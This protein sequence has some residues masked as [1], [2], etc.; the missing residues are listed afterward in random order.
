MKIA[1]NINFDSLYFPLSIDRTLHRDP[2]FFQIADRFFAIANE[3]GISCTLFMI[4]RDLENPEV[5][6]RVKSWSSEGHEIG[7]HSWTHHENLGAMSDDFQRD[8][9]TRSH[10][11]IT[12]TTGIEPRGYIAPT[13]STSR[14]TLQTLI[15]LNYLYDTSAFP[16]P[17]LYGALAKLALISRIHGNFDTRMFSRND[18]KI[19]LCGNRKPY[20]ALPEN[21]HAHN[22][23]GILMLPLPTVSIFRLPVWHTMAFFYPKF[24]FNILVK[25]A[26]EQAGFY[27]LAHPADLSDLSVDIPHN[28]L[29]THRNSFSPFERMD[30]P[31]AK[32]IALM[33]GIIEQL[34]KEHSFARLDEIATTIKT[35]L[36]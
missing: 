16:S 18:K 4:G 5:A 27:Y 13:W 31:L 2:S 21:M 22:D 7:N 20:L 36:V 19:T 32:K 8:E 23:T 1:W 34:S 33:R 12:M 17:I 10:E 26:A 28:I 9:I 6:A 3:F 25:Y 15:D 29:E 30:V 24:L 11:L 14:A 35:Q